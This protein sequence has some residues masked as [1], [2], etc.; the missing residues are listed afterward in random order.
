MSDVKRNPP[1]EIVGKDGPAKSVRKI[2]MV[3]VFDDETEVDALA[4]AVA[5]YSE[6]VGIA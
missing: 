2:I 6:K 1:I 3:E 4:G 5:A